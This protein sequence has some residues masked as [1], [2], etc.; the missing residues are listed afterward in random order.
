MAEQLFAGAGIGYRVRPVLPPDVRQVS[1]LLVGKG[2]LD[3]L[4]PR[5]HVLP[6]ATKFSDGVPT[7]ILPLPESSDDLFAMIQQALQVRLEESTIHVLRGMLW[8]EQGNCGEAFRAFAQAKALV[9]DLTPPTFAPGFPARA[10]AVENLK[11][12]AAVHVRPLGAA[13]GSAIAAE[14]LL[15]L[16]RVGG[17]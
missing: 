16:E 7:P 15:R 5:Y 13:T 12:M 1:A 3:A 11:R 6:V 4:Q 17:R 8:L 2:M 10:I 9:D 14:Y